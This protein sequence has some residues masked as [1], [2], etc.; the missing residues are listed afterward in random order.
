[1]AGNY[2]IHALTLAQMAPLLRVEGEMPGPLTVT[3]GWFRASVRPWN[4]EVDTPMVRLERGGTEFLGAVTRKLH[5]LGAK[6]VFSPALYA[7]ATRVWR[8]SGYEPHASLIVME[9]SLSEP[10][11]TRNA[12]SIEVV[13][14]PDWDRIAEV[15]RASF[16][17]FW[18][19]SR[20]GLMEAHGTNRDTALLTVGDQPDG[21]AIVGA[22]WGTAYL[23]RIGVSRAS[24]GEGKGRALLGAAIRWAASTGARSMVLNVR[25][26][27]ERARAIYRRAG[28]VE[29][30]S[31]LAV[32]KH[33]TSDVLD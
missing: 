30:I 8:R 33:E 22:Q 11:P 31:Q 19:M 16:D 26:D 27:N 3:A 14:D 5:Q 6:R 21:Y 7:G 4:D 15:D 13:S 29:A 20:S 17:G 9:R 18:R 32:L 24:T 12:H 10:P 25:P 1:M 28:F 23:H 2:D